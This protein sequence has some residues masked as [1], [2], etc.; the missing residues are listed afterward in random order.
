MSLYALI[1]WPVSVP[2]LLLGLL[3]STAIGYLA[4]QRHSLSHS[5]VVGAI[6]TGTLIFGFGGWVAGLTLIA[7]FVYSSVLS[8]YKERRKNEVA[9]DKFEK[10]SRRDIGQALANGGPAA[11]LAVFFFLYRDQ[12]WI[13]AAFIGAMATSNADTWATELGVLSPHRP[14]MITS[15]KVVTPGTSGGITLLGSSAAAMG[16]LVIGLSVWAFIGGRNLLDSSVNWT[17]YWWVVPA[18]L[19]GGLLGTMFDSFLGATVQAMFTNPETGKETEK[20]VARNGVKNE[21]KRGL[22]F[23]D[24]DAVNFLSACMG[25][26]VAAV[27]YLLIK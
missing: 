1:S 15:G 10:G 12:I 27:F 21:F 19:L 13:F 16:G 23:M 24:N 7:F 20:R 2:R 5:G 8:K 3:I 17:S 26:G 22:N 14:R 9:A 4:Y 6:I 18:G 25:A 11:L